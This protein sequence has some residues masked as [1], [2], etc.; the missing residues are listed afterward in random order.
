MTGLCFWF[1][2]GLILDGW[3]HNHNIGG[4]SI[5][6]PYHYLFYSGFFTIVLFFLFTTILNIKN[7]TTP[8]K[9][10]P[11]G[12]ILTLFGIVIMGVGGTIDLVWH[13]IFGVEQSIEALLSPSH[14]LIFLGTGLI[15]LGPINS[16]WCQLQT[17]F[18]FKA[19]L[20]MIINVA[21]FIT[22]LNFMTHYINPLVGPFSALNHKA[23][24]VYYG[25]TIG[26]SGTLLQTVIIFGS[27]LFFLTRWNLL[28]G[29]LTIIFTINAV[30]MSLMTDHY[31]ITLSIILAGIICDLIMLTIKPSFSI[32]RLRIFAFLAPIAYYSCYYINILI[33]S[34]TWWSVHVLT[35][36]ILEAGFAGLM[37]SYLLIPKRIKYPS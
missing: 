26:L 31:E 32:L 6:T 29:S 21:L 14:L 3:A 11:H 22:L 34:K 30:A 19:Q 23:A 35:G 33:V 28:P 20:P 37:L 1:M 25:Y 8:S 17:R 12:Y 15:L 27:V 18:K 7:G 5:L 16:A 36:I 10:F 4:D 2:S 13:S 9:A 24:G